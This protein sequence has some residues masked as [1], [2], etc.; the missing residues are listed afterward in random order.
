MVGDSEMGWL[1]VLPQEQVGTGRNAAHSFDSLHA[2]ISLREMA[3]VFPFLA[4]PTADLVID[5]A[6]KAAPRERCR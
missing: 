5:A 2:K 4:L 6:T 3:N 1:H